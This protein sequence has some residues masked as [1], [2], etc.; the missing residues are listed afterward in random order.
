MVGIASDALTPSERPVR[1][2]H[3]LVT[4]GLVLGLLMALV[5]PAMAFGAPPAA[6]KVE[7][8]VTLDAPPLAQAIASSRALTAQ[9]RSARLNLRSPTSVSYLRSLAATQR[10]LAR[11]I[12]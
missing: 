8:V 12:V 2:I 4:R 7:V 5:A 6:G 1:T 10:A 9:A 3:D 11:R